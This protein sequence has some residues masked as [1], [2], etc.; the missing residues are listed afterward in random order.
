MLET[1]VVKAFSFAF[2]VRRP[3]LRSATRGRTIQMYDLVGI[4]REYPTWRT[5]RRI[6]PHSNSAPT[7]TTPDLSDPHPRRR[8]ACLRA[9]DPSRANAALITV[10][11]D[12]DQRRSWR[13]AI[14]VL[15]VLNG[16]D[17]PSAL[18]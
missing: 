3:P 2:S 12:E 13:I 18:P 5:T 15:E 16:P 6:N 17:I 8:A 14:E 4:R 10:L 7:I 9:S 11:Q 1:A